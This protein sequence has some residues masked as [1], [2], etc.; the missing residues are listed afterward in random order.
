MKNKGLIT[1]CDFSCRFVDPEKSWSKSARL[2][3]YLWSG[4]VLSKRQGYFDHCDIRRLI[5]FSSNDLFFLAG[6]LSTSA[7]LRRD[8]YAWAAKLAPTRENLWSDHRFFPNR[9]TCRTRALCRTEIARASGHHLHAPIC[10]TI[11]RGR[12]IGTTNRSV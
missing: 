6:L 11:S 12:Q 9:P 10:F 5:S 4:L 1:R 7:I 3:W 8:T 2:F